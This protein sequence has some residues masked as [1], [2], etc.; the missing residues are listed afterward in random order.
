MARDGV[1]SEVRALHRRA[2]SPGSA[3]PSRPLRARTATMA[4]APTVAPTP[5]SLTKTSLQS[6]LC[7]MDETVA[8]T[9]MGAVRALAHPLRLQLLDLL[10]FEGPSTAT[11][12]A[13]RV[14][15]SSGATSYHLRQ[16]ARFGYLDEMPGRS[17][18][19]RWWRYRERPVVVSGGAGDRPGRQ[20]VAE[21]MTREADALDRFLAAGPPEPA[22]DAASFFRTRALRL[23]AAELEELRRGIDA[24]LAPLRRADDE[25]PPEARPVR[26]LVFG[27]PLSLERT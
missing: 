13:R 23:T 26:L 21:L 6:Y 19:E 8:P 2:G 14:G 4:T 1:V 5:K 25:A 9:D 17:G 7:N 24:L 11:L 27:F 10:R 22:W 3:E 16:L 20:L 12:L 18:R 15:E